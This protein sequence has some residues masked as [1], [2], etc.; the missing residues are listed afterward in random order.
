[1][2]IDELTVVIPAYNAQ[3]TIERSVRSG[4]QCASTVLVVDDGSTDGTADCAA[5][6]GAIVI[7]QANSGAATARRAGVERVLTP[8]ALLLDA[9]DVLIAQGVEVS[10]RI[11]RTH[12]CAAVVGSTLAR[13]GRVTRCI[14]P[15][16]EGVS[17]DTLLQ[18]GIAPGPPG[19][20]VWNSVS[21]RASYSDSWPGVWPRYSEDYELIVRG[22]LIG[23]ILTHSALVCE[24]SMVGGKSNLAPMSSLECAENIRLH[25]AA[26]L[27]VELQP[28]GRRALRAV[29]CL[30]R[31]FESPGLSSLHQRLWLYARACV[32]SPNLFI[33][34]ANSMMKR[35]RRAN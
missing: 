7:R 34:A 11:A 22:S 25:Y 15:W 20:I 19:A 3:S 8:F 24:Y 29:V 12:E 28:R 35:V 10:L 21:L 13:A 14:T 27:G 17:V 32:L 18:R 4:L 16:L 5:E 31:A 33:R 1:M 9:D 26:T 6:A 2:T 30:R 23:P